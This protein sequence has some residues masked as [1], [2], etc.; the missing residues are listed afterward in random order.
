MKK[1]LFMKKFQDLKRNSSI[2]YIAIKVIQP[3][4]SEVII[5]DRSMFDS[6]FK[7]Y[8]GAYDDEM[9]L[10]SFGKILIVSIEG[11]NLVSNLA[12]RIFLQK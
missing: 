4:G 9:Q 5:F 12:S 6:K 8:E 2:N 7:Y 3:G 10:K 11:G 1:S